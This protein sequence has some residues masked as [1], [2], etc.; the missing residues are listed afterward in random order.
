MLPA[1][2]VSTLP[3]VLALCFSWGNMV[4]TGT[5]SAAPLVL[6]QLKPKFRLK[7]EVFISAA[8]FG[9]NGSSC[10]FGFGSVHKDWRGLSMGLESSRPSHMP[11]LIIF[12]QRNL[13]GGNGAKERHSCVR[14]PFPLRTILSAKRHAAFLFLTEWYFAFCFSDGSCWKETCCSTT[15]GK[16]TGILLG[17][18]FWK[19]ALWSWAKWMTPTPSPSSLCFRVSQIVTRFDTCKCSWVVKSLSCP[20]FAPEWFWNV[21]SQEVEAERTSWQL[22]HKRIWNPGW[23]P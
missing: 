8:G 11:K 20:P 18:S 21:V 10:V 13:C 16:K 3:T 9:T 6:R 15:R 5:P 14:S 19:A 17:W 2:R 23:K 7:V 4:E 22:T 1:R 12:F